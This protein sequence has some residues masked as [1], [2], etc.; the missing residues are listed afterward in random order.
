VSRHSGCLFMQ[1]IM[2][3]LLATDVTASHPTNVKLASGYEGLVER[4]VRLPDGARL[5]T[6]ASM[7]KTAAM[8]VRVI[9]R[10]IVPHFPSTLLFLEPTVGPRWQAFSFVPAVNE[11]LAELA[12][13]L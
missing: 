3:F 11:A 2:G 5:A 12:R 6:V 4:C 7:T 9:L 10:K 8:A 13:P 1:Q